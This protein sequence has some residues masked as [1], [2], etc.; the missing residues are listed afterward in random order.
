[1]QD[2]DAAT[3]PLHHLFAGYL[4]AT[5]SDL[6]II[7]EGLVRLGVP[8]LAS[9]ADQSAQA[10]S[11]ASIYDN[12]RDE[13]MADFPWAFAVKQKVLASLAI[14][15]SSF[16]MK[17]YKYAYQ[18]PA[19]NLRIL[20]LNNYSHFALSGDQVYT[21]DDNAT[22]LYI[23]RAPV[24]MWPP[25][26]VELVAIELAAALS[27]T[28]TDSSSRA[29]LFYRLAGR[30]RQRARSIDSQQTPNEV[31]QTVRAYSRRHSNWL[32]GA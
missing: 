14:S 31:F 10:I 15:P 7:N 3:I 19:D 5:S 4:V 18:L 11:V 24:G 32:R 25:Y 26:F 12:I 13:I 1:M 20:G 9:L 17:G 6:S 22:L 8:P 16:R 21:D 23:Y 27:M 30:N 29:E 2:D 28:L